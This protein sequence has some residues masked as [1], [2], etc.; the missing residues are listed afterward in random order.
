MDV[1]IKDLTIARLLKK[2]TGIPFDT[3]GEDGV[4]VFKDMEQEKLGIEVRKY[5]PEV[6]SC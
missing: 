2:K 4:Y 5:Q 1:Y 3:D 6:E